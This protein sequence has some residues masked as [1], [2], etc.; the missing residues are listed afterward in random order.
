MFELS[1]FE[2]SLSLSKEQKVESKHF[3]INKFDKNKHKT[4][5]FTFKPEQ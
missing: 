1:V 5:K 2:I 4:Y 3:I